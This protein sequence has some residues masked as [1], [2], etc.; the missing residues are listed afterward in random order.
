LGGYGSASDSDAEPEQQQ[1]QQRGAGAGD[2]KKVQ[3][4]SAEDALAGA[5]PWDPDAEKEPEEPRRRFGLLGAQDD[6]EL[7][8]WGDGPVQEEQAAAAAVA[9]GQGHDRAKRWV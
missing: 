3:L 4:P 5:R 6:T 9:A 2:A 1:Q 7:L 8:D